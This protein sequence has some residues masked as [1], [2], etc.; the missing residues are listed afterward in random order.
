MK[1]SLKKEKAKK[2]NTIIVS[3]VMIFLMTF[4]ILAMTLD[5]SNNQTSF[6]Y[7]NFTFKQKVIDHEIF[8]QQ[9]QKYYIELNGEDI[10][11]YFTPSFMD[12]INVSADNLDNLKDSNVI[13]FTREPLSDELDVT[14]NIFFFDVLR[15]EFNQNVP[16]ATSPAI[17]DETIFE[18]DLP[19]INCEDASDSQVVLKLANTTGPLS[20][21]EINPYCFEIQ[22]DGDDLLYILD[23]LIYDYYDVI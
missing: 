8:Q 16:K 12:Q 17:T 5:S 18:S 1:P 22:G 15:L 4:S 2:R 11:F 3:L 19:V 14:E 9:V 6:E 20:I 21:N 13:Y 10:E 23:Y 7:N